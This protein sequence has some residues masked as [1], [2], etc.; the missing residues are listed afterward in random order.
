LLFQ[1]SEEPT[2]KLS[3]ASLFD[4]DSETVQIQPQQE[5]Q[6]SETMAATTVYFSSIPLEKYVI[7][8]TEK[9]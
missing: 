1:R 7:I 2:R 3:F 8:L 4:D 9:S 5:N 6:L